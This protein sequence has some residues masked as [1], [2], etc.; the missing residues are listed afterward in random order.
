MK[1][2]AIRLTLLLITSVGV[3]QSLDPNPT[4]QSLLKKPGSR[5]IR[6][7]ALDSAA[8]CQARYLAKT[9]TYGHS[10]PEGSGLETPR[11]RVQ[12]QGDKTSRSWYEVAWAGD[13][14][15]VAND[16]ASAVMLFKQSEKHWHI[17]TEGVDR[18]YDVKV[19]YSRIKI[20]DYEACVIL[21]CF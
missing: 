16:A 12:A 10:Q 3:S 13:T 4:L 20:G 6:V 7:P 2:L 5:I 15:W 11:K 21:Y 18:G 17:M 9:R 1:S 19:G 8:A 14:A